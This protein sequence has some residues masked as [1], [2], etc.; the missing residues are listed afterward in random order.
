MTLLPDGM[1]VSYNRNT[2]LYSVTDSSG[3]RV[4]MTEESFDEFITKMDSTI[5][6]LD[7][8]RS[9]LMGGTVVTI[10]EGWNEDYLSTGAIQEVDA[11]NPKFGGF[12]D[13]LE[14]QEAYRTVF[15]PTRTEQLDR[16]VHGLSTGRTVSEDIKTSYMES[17]G[18]ISA[19]VDNI[20]SQFDTQSGITEQDVEDVRADNERGGDEPGAE[21]EEEPP[22]L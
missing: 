18:D 22:T 13:A 12:D 10:R 16:V 3:Q 2:E 6:D 8:F 14:L 11:V 1:A 21:G 7:N 19:T 20:G 9:R 5:S 15:Y 4:E 17:D